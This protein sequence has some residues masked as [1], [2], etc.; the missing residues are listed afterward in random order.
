MR[1]RRSDGGAPGGCSDAAIGCEAGQLDRRVG[2][3]Q[4]LIAQRTVGPDGGQYDR[5][6]DCEIRWQKESCFSKT[7][8]SIAD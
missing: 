1:P 8:A 6:A 4:P 3:S 5:M 7:E 2:S